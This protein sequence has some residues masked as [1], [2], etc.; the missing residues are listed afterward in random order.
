MVIDG[1]LDARDHHVLSTIACTASA[2]SSTW[3]SSAR[4]STKSPGSEAWRDLAPRLAF[5]QAIHMAHQDFWRFTEYGIKY[6]LKD[7]HTRSWRCRD[8]TEIEAFPGPN[9]E[10]QKQ[11]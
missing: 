9:G 8:R 10:G 2:C 3:T 4:A 11:K 7:S 1:S 6:L 5:R